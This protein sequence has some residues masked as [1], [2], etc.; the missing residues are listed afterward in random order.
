MDKWVIA[1][2]GRGR[3]GESRLARFAVVDMSERILC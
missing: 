1:I 2:V 3:E